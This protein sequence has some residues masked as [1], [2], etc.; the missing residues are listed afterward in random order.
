MPK[1]QFVDPNE[2]RKSGWIKF[3]DIPVNQY[4]KTLEEE[5]QNFSDDQLIRIY[6][7]MLIIREFETMLSLIKTTGEYNGI[8]YDYPG[9]AHLSIGQEAAA[10]GQAFVL[11]K[12]DFIFGSHRSHGEVIA[13]G[14]STIEKLSEDELLKIMESY[15]DGAILKVVEENIKNVVSVKELA[16]N[17][18]LY[19]TL[20]EIFGR[21][22][23][24]QK[25]LGGSM[26]V[27]FPP[28]G[29]YPNNAIVG[30]SADIAVGRSF[31]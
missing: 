25:G 24:F 30:G 19:G 29:I 23:G 28:F 7:D 3:Y 6:R 10:V 17:F 13:K 22:T 4:N 2:V 16:V 1:S 26:H 20:A 15:F 27:F 18:F 14:L 12:D 9:P 21:E 11:D 5:R 8:K 31:V